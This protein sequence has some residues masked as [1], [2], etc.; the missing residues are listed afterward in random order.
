MVY[1]NAD[2]LF[3]VNSKIKRSISTSIQFSTQDI[4][5]AKLSFNL[6]KDGVPLPIS[7]ATHA[8]L[9]MRFTDGSQV[10]V[11]TEVEDALKG[12]IFYVLT[13]EQV[14][15]YGT[16][17]AELYVNYDN[18][19]KMSV[20]KFSFEIDRALVDQD[21]APVAE[22]YIDDFESLKAAVQE[23][24]DDAERVIAE[25]Q[26]KFENLDNIETK[27]GAQEKAD[28]AETGAKAYTDEHASKKNNPHKV[29]KAQV[30][31]SNVDNVKQA[32][33]ID[34]DSHVGNKSNPHAVTKAQ[35]GLSNVDNV[36]QAAK[37]E[38]DTHT[39]DNVRHITANERTKWNGGQLKK[40]SADDG[41]VTAIAYNG[42]D[43]LEKVTS[44]GKGM[45]TFYA[46]GGAVNSPT[47]LSNR[48]MFHFTSTD[49]EGKGTFG[50]VISTDYKNNVYT[51]YRDGNLG[52]MGWR[53]LVP[54]SELES[55]TWVKVTLKNGA[56][57]GDR[58]VQYTKVGNT[59]QIR[60]HVTTNRE[61]VFGS[62]P[63]SFAPTS[64]AVVNVSVSGTMGNSKLIIYPEGDL[65][66]TGI[67][68][69]NDGA[70]TGYYLDVVVPIN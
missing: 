67:Q 50:W 29:T 27:E 26:K 17:Q 1:K 40:I 8:K 20:H 9:F 58:T 69:N 43:V 37:T 18:G 46:A 10:Y 2:I 60:G 57:S 31:L 51:N 25:L 6:T 59:L 36:K 64:G 45:G 55:P 30:G 41:G 33:K 68:S 19:Q 52:W 66:L 12:V 54:S 3:D 62:I 61:V 39:A 34:F 63:S 53:R 42:E 21:I 7:K 28:A 13:P 65:K 23:M 49:A 14:K 35:V 32:A 15:H 48:G 70:V 4:G 24:A 44:L 56:K 47:P 38:F 22:Y 5:T 11:N 16:V